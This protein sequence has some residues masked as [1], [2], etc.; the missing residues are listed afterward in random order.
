MDIYILVCYNGI[1]QS[2]VTVTTSEIEAEIFQDK[3][4]FDRDPEDCSIYSIEH[5][6]C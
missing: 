5:W 1:L 4:L 6:E 3:L 2:N